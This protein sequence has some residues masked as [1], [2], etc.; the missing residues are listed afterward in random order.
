MPYLYPPEFRRRILH[1]LAAGRSVPSLSA[2]LGVS[3]QTIYNW[4]RQDTI[5]RGLEPVMAITE[6]PQS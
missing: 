2:D 3:D 1:L 5:D 6:I 4:Q